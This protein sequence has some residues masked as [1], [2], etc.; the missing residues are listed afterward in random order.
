MFYIVVVFFLFFLANF[1]QKTYLD[2]FEFPQTVIG[3]SAYSSE[4]CPSG[5]T[6]GRGYFDC[7]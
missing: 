4:K 2:G 3:W 5:T 6:N 7:S 1:C